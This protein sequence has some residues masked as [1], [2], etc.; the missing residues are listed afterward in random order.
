MATIAQSRANFDIVAD[1][2]ENLQATLQQVVDLE[3]AIAARDQLEKAIDD[4]RSTLL[5]LIN[6]AT[7]QYGASSRDLRE[8]SAMSKRAVLALGADHS[9]V[10]ALSTYAV[11]GVPPLSR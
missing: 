5:M 9:G 1:D 6:E 11:Q 2:L 7:S 4:R 10:L 8:I 3:S